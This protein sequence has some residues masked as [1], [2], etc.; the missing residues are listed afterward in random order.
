MAAPNYAD[1]LVTDSL[2]ALCEILEKEGQA[3]GVY[4]NALHLLVEIVKQ[5]SHSPVI[6]SGI[7]DDLVRWLR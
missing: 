3:L 1:R 5:S 2:Q 7:V 4:V 6:Q